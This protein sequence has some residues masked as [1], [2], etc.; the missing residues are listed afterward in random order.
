MSPLSSSLVCRDQDIL[1]PPPMTSYSLEFCSC[2][3]S[4]WA[5]S[6]SWNLCRHHLK[7]FCHPE[8]FDVLFFYEGINNLP[9]V[10]EVTVE[11]LTNE[12]KMKINYYSPYISWWNQTPPRTTTR[13]PWT[14]MR[15]NFGLPHPIM[16]TKVLRPDLTLPLPLP[17]HR[18]EE[19]HVNMEAIG[20]RC[21]HIHHSLLVSK[22]IFPLPI[23]DQFH[24]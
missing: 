17:I 24:T 23:T 14:K 22:K 3:N 18:K 4:T 12:V 15:K 8:C 20:H 13:Q 19:V 2:R 6:T 1:D 11:E 5:T 9:Q 21:N 7:I 16:G 10:T